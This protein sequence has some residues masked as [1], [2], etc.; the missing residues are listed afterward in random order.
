MIQYGRNLK[1]LYEI[2]K[3][4][5]KDHILYDAIY[6]KCPEETNRHRKQLS[7]AGVGGRRWGLTANGCAVSFWD[8]FGHG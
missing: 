4:S 2:T 7:R 3:A 8:D 6:M 5:H 1:M